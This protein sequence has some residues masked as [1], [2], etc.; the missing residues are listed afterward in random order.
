VGEK[1]NNFT[2]LTE[3]KKYNEPAL[4]QELAQGSAAAFDMIYLHYYEAVRANIFKIVRDDQTTDD[5]LQ[6]VFIS[7]WEKREKFAGYDKIGGWL[8][9]AS[10]NRS[11]NFLRRRATEQVYKRSLAGEREPEFDPSAELLQEQ[12]FRLLEEAI[13][14]L[15][16]QRKKVFELCRLQ[17]KTYEEAAQELS[18]SKNTV[19]E[20]LSK[21][22]DSIKNYVST[23]STDPM[24]LAS[25]ALMMCM[26]DLS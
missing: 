17:G 22:G 25:V 5:I 11:M 7:C 6:E 18:I 12:Q 26:S 24:I 20:Y 23:H 10:Y 2:G 1:R 15:P 16:P 3:I 9:V 19:K 4:L 13:A 21:A 14:N 8:F